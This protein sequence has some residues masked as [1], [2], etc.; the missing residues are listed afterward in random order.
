LAWWCAR[1]ARRPGRVSRAASSLLGRGSCV[2]GVAGAGRTCVR[3]QCVGDRG[4]GVVR[5]IRR[6]AGCRGEWIRRPRL[7]VLWAGGWG[8]C[9]QASKGVWGMSWRREAQGRDRRRNARGSGQVRSDPG[10]PEPTG[11]TETSQYPQEGKATATP[12][13]AASER[14]PAQ[15]GGSHPPG[16]KD[17]NVDPSF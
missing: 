11:G 7:P 15:T 8:R 17:R 4:L 2:A 16:L 9:G 1:R 6:D 5:L 10:V 12:S 3:L 13:V 14:G